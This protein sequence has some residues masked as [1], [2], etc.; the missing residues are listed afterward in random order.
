MR[1]EDLSALMR[2]ERAR[3]TKI[4]DGSSK[5]IKHLMPVFILD[6]LRDS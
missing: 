4:E 6:E 5:G 3:V 2:F 1:F